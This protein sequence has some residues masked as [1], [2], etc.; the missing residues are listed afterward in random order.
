MKRIFYSAITGP[1]YN[2]QMD[3]EIMEAEYGE[4][5]DGDVSG[6]LYNIID[7]FPEGTEILEGSEHI[8]GDVCH[9]FTAAPANI[10]VVRYDGE[11]RQIWWSDTDE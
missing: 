3:C 5:W 10:C 7:K 9:H 8:P 4:E 11:A 1:D 2:R 6:Y